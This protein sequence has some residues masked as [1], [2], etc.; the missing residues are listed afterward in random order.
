MIE[1]VQS[2]LEEEQKQMSAFRGRAL[3]TDT[4]DYAT[5]HTLEE[6]RTLRRALYLFM[7]QRTRSR[8]EAGLAVGNPCCFCVATMVS[9]EMTFAF[10]EA[11]SPVSPL[12]P[13]SDL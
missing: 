1:D 13:I 9:W 11:S 10:P 6:V 4:F 2:L 8:V 3:S 7:A 12:L 5:Y